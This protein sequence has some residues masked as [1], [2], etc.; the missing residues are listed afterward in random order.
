[1]N[2]RK[3]VHTRPATDGGGDHGSRGTRK[4]RGTVSRKPSGGSSKRPTGTGDRGT[5]TLAPT[6]YLPRDFQNP[7][8]LERLYPDAESGT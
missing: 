3:T 8:P 6:V 2:R 1:M 7:A 5:G 4:Q